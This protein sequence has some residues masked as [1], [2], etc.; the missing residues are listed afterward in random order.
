M[1][2]EVPRWRC[3]LLCLMM[4]LSHS[5]ITSLREFALFAA[6]GC[7]TRNPKKPSSLSDKLKGYILRKAR[8]PFK[9]P[10]PEYRGV[11]ETSHRCWLTRD[12]QFLA[13]CVVLDRI[14]WH[15]SSRMRRQCTFLKCV[16][17]SRS[18]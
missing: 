1:G 13:I 17:R 2:F 18:P 16:A 15:S 14:I 6:K 7:P 11:P 12:L 5:S 10:M 3:V 4:I 8:M 9:S